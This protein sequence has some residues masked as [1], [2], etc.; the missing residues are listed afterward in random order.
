MKIGVVG[1]GYVGSRLVEFLSNQGFKVVAISRSV[2]N[3]IQADVTRLET[4][5][6]IP[7]DIT[8]LVYCVAPDLH[9]D[10]GYRETYVYGLK[11]LIQYCSSNLSNL[12]R[13]IFVSSTSVHG[14]DNGEWVDESSPTNPIKFS[15]IRM[16]EAEQL[17]R[18]TRFSSVILR[19]SGIYGR[20]R[21]RILA[22][23]KNGEAFISENKSY[24]NRIH[25]E[26]CVGAIS[27]LL[28]AEKVESVYLGTDCRPVDRSE[29]ILWIASHFGYP[30]PKKE[31]KLTPKENL[32]GSNKR[33]S[34]KRLLESGYVFKYPTYKEGLIDCMGV[35]IL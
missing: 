22:Q 35:S 24:V 30:E 6:A 26:D 12:G 8:H 1:Y 23:V 4:L 7:L 18:N 11:N 5:D 3:G 27:H 10:E 32:F 16:L 17:C 14:Q 25:R 2:N 13:L 28:L 9:T 31:D 29:L 34:N 19:F 33:L 21:S 15:G 20:G